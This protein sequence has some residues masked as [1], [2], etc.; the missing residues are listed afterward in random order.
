MKNRRVL[1][2]GKKMDKAYIEIL[3]TRLEYFQDKKIVDL[4]DEEIQ[5]FMNLTKEINVQ[6]SET[7]E[8]IKKAAAPY[9]EAQSKYNERVL[10]K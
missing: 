9:V 8:I 1:K 5:E 6:F 3:K 10:N 4:S 2:M 7:I